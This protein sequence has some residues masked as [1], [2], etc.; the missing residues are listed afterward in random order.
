M[1]KPSS[2][3]YNDSGLSY[4]SSPLASYQEDSFK[5]TLRRLGIDE[6][7]FSQNLLELLH[8]NNNRHWQE[9]DAS[10][11]QMSTIPPTIQRF[12]SLTH[13]NLSCNHISI[14]PE[15]ICQL[16]RMQYLV[17]SENQI[18]A[19]PNDL[20]HFLPHLLILC[21]DDNRLT[22]LPDT[23]GQWQ[24]IRELRLGSEFGGNLIQQLP[25]SLLSIHSLV[26]LDV[27]FNQIRA[28]SSFT[29]QY[30]NKLRYINLSHN[31]LTELPQDGYTFQSC[32]QLSTLDLSDNFITEL[33]L[34][35]ARDLTGL[36]AHGVLELLN[37]SDNRLRT[38]PTEIL[39][40]IR[41][42]VVIMGNPLVEY[43]S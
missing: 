36:M 18:T 35:N 27:S 23:I 6:E 28:L 42:Q 11:N 40:Q 8:G 22:E 43:H 10:R 14:I 25:S 33:T 1:I 29:F 19:I 30:M 12:T 26:E 20:P 15:A 17:L 41:T 37:L 13:L 32:R 21:S 2:I 31:Q 3:R 5:I 16:T 4:L 9:L 39:D 24:H 34:I 7:Q 38:I